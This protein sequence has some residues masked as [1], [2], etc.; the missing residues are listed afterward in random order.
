[1]IAGLMAVVVAGP[2]L[3]QAV[4]GSAKQM[5]TDG[6]ALMSTEQSRLLIPAPRQLAWQEM[7]YHAFVH[8]GINTF[9]DREWGDGTENRVRLLIR[10]ARTS[11]AISAFGLFKASLKEGQR[12]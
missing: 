12:E 6:E 4:A 11:P 7:E 9:T 1:M 3:A 2:C 8:F 10:D 5:K